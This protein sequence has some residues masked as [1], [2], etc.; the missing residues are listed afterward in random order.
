MEH[1]A[2]RVIPQIVEKTAIPPGQVT[3]LELVTWPIKDNSKLTQ[4]SQ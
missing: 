3:F 2:G 1:T 4:S